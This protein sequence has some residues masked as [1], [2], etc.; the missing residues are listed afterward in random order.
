MH[1]DVPSF[2][3]KYFLGSFTVYFSLKSFRMHVCAAQS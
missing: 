1:Y 3:R 2:A